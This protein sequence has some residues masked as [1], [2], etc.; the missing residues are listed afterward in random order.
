[1]T[2]LPTPRDLLGQETAVRAF[3]AAIATNRVAGA[4]LLCGPAGI[5]RSLGASLFAHALLCAH[6][7]GLVACGAC[8]AC[9]WNALGTHPDLFVI[10]ADTGPRFDD[11]AEAARAGID[12]FGRAA[13]AAAKAGPRKTI[14]V[15]TLRRLLELLS[16]TA[17]GGGWKVVLLDAFDD[18]EEEG[19]ALLLKTLEEAPPQTTFL[20]LARGTDSVPDTIL[21]RCQRVRF[22]PLAPDLVRRIASARGGAPFAALDPAAVDVVCRLAQGSPG[23]AIATAALGITGVP[24]AAVRTL[25]VVPEPPADLVPWMKEG[26]KDL[27]AQR[28]RVREVLALALVGVRDGWVPAGEG[29]IAAIRAALESVESNVGPDWALRA[30]WIRCA[31]ARAL[32]T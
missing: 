3:E 6:R 7:R 15:R 26:A 29:A 12:R 5:G 8:R 31:R 10:A 17:A 20:L 21:S 24:L 28:E 1:M 16:L 23:R 11:D 25:G 4:Y 22:R 13:R 9:R 14:G 19:T 2:D 32:S 18:V 27:E 30:L